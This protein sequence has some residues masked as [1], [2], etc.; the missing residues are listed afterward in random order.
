MPMQVSEHPPESEG[1]S[2]GAA[3]IAA[4]AEIAEAH[5][6]GSNRDQRMVTRYGVK[7]APW[8]ERLGWVKR[9]RRWYAA[10]AANSDTRAQGG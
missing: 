10:V 7:A 9:G 8:L 3:L 6:L 4:G 5:A 1:V 2:I